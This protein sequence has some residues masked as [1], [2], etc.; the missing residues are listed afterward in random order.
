M[1]EGYK[2]LLERIYNADLTDAAYVQEQ[3]ITAARYLACKNALLLM[4]EQ[5]ERME[6]EELPRTLDQALKIGVGIGDIGLEL[7]KD[8]AV[9]I[10]RFNDAEQSIDTGFYE[11]QK[12]IGG[13]Y[14]GEETIIVAPPN[15]GKTAL[16]GNLAYGAARH[17]TTVLYYTLEIGAERMLCRFYAKMAA[18]ATRDLQANI[19]KVRR[20]IKRFSLSTHGTVYVKFFPARAAS[21][22]T[23]RNHLSMVKSQDIN[24]KLVVVD[25]ADLLRPSRS[26]NKTYEQLR[27]THEELRAMADEFSVHLMT[28][29]QSTRDTLYADFID[30]DKMA[31]SWGKAQTADDVIALCQNI[32]EQ[33]AAVARLYIA[34]A[35]NE[36][37]GTIVHIAT[38]YKHLNIREVDKKVYT[39]QLLNAGFET[40][41][42]GNLARKG[43]KRANSNALRRKYDD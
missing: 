42:N 8:M 7:T 25:Y 10:L 30:L 3:M 37:R 12:A 6:F 11:L 5:N 29:S 26:T 16:L 24:P 33:E 19:P 1:A 2:I 20:N 18:V 34:K 13:F 21:V 32:Q 40:D 41:N 4:A 28:A 39:S 17:D 9:A 15:I 38:N 31:E 23:I 27:E 35:R 22:D 43:K 14:T 36:T